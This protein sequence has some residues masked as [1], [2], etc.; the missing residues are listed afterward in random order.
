MLT[1][2]DAPSAPFCGLPLVAAAELQDHLLAVS[3]DL[4]R[5]QALLSHS[6]EALLQSFHDIS[7]QLRG[8]HEAAD[9]LHP[10]SQTLGTAISALG[11]AVVALQFEDMASQLIQHT[12]RRL[13]NCVD[14]L[15]SET[16]ADDEDGPALVREAPQ[17]PNP[18]TQ[19][20]MDA[21]SVELF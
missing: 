20:E 1:F 18:V 12:H 2:D 16:F 9:P 4:D 15:A 14:Q 3:H 5:L 10:C 17:H 6:C 7:G 19:D 11:A 13:R 21:G 8:L